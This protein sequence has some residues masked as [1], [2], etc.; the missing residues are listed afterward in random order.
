MN[1]N[2]RRCGALGLL[3]LVIAGAQETSA[4]TSGA[5]PAAT[6]RAA[7]SM[8]AREE[9][10]VFSRR[11]LLEKV[12]ASSAVGAALGVV[13]MPRSAEAAKKVKAVGEGGFSVGGGMLSGGS[14]QDFSIE[15][16]G[17]DSNPV[18]YSF[19]YP[20]RWTLSRNTGIMVTDYGTTDKAYALV[21]PLPGNVKWIADLNTKW[22]TNLIFDKDGYYSQYGPPENVKIVEQHATEK[23]GVPYRFI[24]LSFS[25][26]TPNGILS[27][28]RACVAAVAVGKDVF[29][30][31]SS[32]QNS[33]WSKVRGEVSEMMESFRAFKAPER[34]VRGGDRPLSLGEMGFTGTDSD[35][36]KK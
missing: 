5:M 11:A 24:D 29:L 28:R 34:T 9:S 16:T 31:V 22:F 27:A 26:L 7:V 25:V 17:S 4:W 12:A 30:L 18:V 3:A 33:R 19:S 6:R 2:R 13:A 14:F 36:S 15:A 20:A 1:L 32:I 23:R 35:G 10:A 8:S 21:A